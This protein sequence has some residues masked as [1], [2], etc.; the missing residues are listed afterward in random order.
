MMQ[1]ILTINVDYPLSPIIQMRKLEL[2]KLGYPAQNVCSFK[3]D[4]KKLRSLLK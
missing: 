1:I 4:E 2:I 3:R